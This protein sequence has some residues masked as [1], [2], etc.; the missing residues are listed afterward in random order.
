[1]GRNRKPIS[2]DNPY[3]MRLATMLRDDLLD[4]AKL[5]FEELAQRTK[6][7]E[8][9]ETISRVTLQR[10]ASGTY[11]PKEKTI[12]AFA[13]GCGFPESTEILLRLRTRARIH[14]RGILPE[15]GPIPHP[16]LISDWRD[17]SR[18]IEYLYEAAGA[19]PFR[20]IRDKSGNPHALSVSSLRRII[21][22]IT[23]PVDEQQLLAIIHGC[24]VTDQ[25]PL[26]RA[27]WAKVTSTT[28]GS[29]GETDAPLNRLLKRMNRTSKQ[30]T[31]LYRPMTRPSVYEVVQMMEEQSK[32]GETPRISLLVQGKNGTRMMFGDDLA[33]S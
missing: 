25:D 13:V 33:A 31:P 10:A 26:W 9:I 7:R 21:L 8:G 29:P 23:K 5:T 19:P 12:V 11:L 14:E 28:A 22:R 27:A 20:E 16:T 4:S 32:D 24:G 3:T 1:M 15:F 17:L 18:S 6:K 30:L 2:T